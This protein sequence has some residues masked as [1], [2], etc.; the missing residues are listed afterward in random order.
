MEWVPLRLIPSSEHRLGLRTA[1]LCDNRADISKSA[2]TPL[3]FWH[4]ASFDAPTVAVVWSLAFAWCAAVHLP[5]WVPVVQALG[6]WT[7]Y[8]A[9]R[10]LDA[11]G[12]LRNNALENLRERH[13]FH[14]RHRHIFLPL[15]AAAACLC[16]AL[17]FR[18]MP[19]AG[20]E[21]NSFVAAAALVYF[22]RV[23]SPRMK[24]TRSLRLRFPFLSKEFF[25]GLLFT[26]GCVLPA[27]AR[28]HAAGKPLWPL[29]IAAF[30]FVQLAWLNCRAIEGWE[31]QSPARSRLTCVAGCLLSAACLLLAAM[32]HSDHPRAAALLAAAAESALL[33]ALLDR[34]RSHLAPVTLR[35]AADLALLTPLALLLK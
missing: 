26:T 12:A 35:A 11:R 2:L 10:L 25:V 1:V 34:V 4:L 14:W 13:F 16:A 23:H 24:N 7:V 9:D 20:R 33:L 32:I 29:L 15:A 31:S 3:R 5:P 21:R 17:I 28:S 27:L 22:A 8:V 19:I 30:L 18:F 6:V